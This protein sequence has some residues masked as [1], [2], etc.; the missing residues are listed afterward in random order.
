MTTTESLPSPVDVLS[1]NP[2]YDPR[3]HIIPQARTYCNIATIPG[4]DGVL[5]R[6]YPQDAMD[7]LYGDQQADSP[8]GLL[9]TVTQEE[10]P[11][12]QAQL[13]RLAAL[14]ILVVN[15]NYRFLRLPNT[16]AQVWLATVQHVMGRTL[17][18]DDPEGHHLPAKLKQY[19]AGAEEDPVLSD[20]R[21]AGQFML[22]NAL[23]DGAPR[24]TVMIDP[25]P[26]TNPLHRVLR[27]SHSFDMLDRW[28]Q[29]AQDI[30]AV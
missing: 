15:N 4:E 5:L 19:Y 21:Y 16:G 3:R 30:M 7:D 28:H 23:E 29:A 20:L 12:Y 13:D 11:V 24:R 25:E 8:S 27:N 18:V 10:D 6:W 14:G 2:G 22:E 26:R 1:E 9:Q 17:R